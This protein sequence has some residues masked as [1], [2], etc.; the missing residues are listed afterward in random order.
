MWGAGRRLRGGANHAL[1]TGRFHEGGHVLCPFLFLKLVHLFP[2]CSRT[3]ASVLWSR[4]LTRY[5][6]VSVDLPVC[7]TGGIPGQPF[8]LRPSPNRACTFQC[9]RLSNFSELPEQALRISRTISSPSDTLCRPSSCLRRYPEHYGYYGGSVTL[10]LAT[11][12]RSRLYAPETLSAC[13]L[14]VRFLAPFLAGC[15]P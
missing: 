1:I 10:G 5:R 14:H 11:R 2:G 6:C 13:R 8:S 15:S 3:D 7:S 9:T 12:R 4:R